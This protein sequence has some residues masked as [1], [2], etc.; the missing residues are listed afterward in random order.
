MSQGPRKS[1]VSKPPV[2][3]RIGQASQ[4]KQESIRHCYEIAPQTLN[5][6]FLCL[7]I[8]CHCTEVVSIASDNGQ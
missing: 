5:L 6:L 7:K 4:G 1:S 3:T 2:S 8:E